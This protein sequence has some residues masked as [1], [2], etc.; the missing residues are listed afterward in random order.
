MVLDAEFVLGVLV[1]A[2]FAVLLGLGYLLLKLIA[3]E[4]RIA[5]NRQTWLSQARMQVDRLR[6]LRR[7]LERASYQLPAL[8]NLGGGTR[9]AKL[10]RLAYKALAAS[11]MARS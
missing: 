5:E 1:L 9:W 3:A 4:N 2:E 7:R 8:E 10:A 11:R 6:A